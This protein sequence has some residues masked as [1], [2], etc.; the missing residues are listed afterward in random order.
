MLGVEFRGQAEALAGDMGGGA[1]AGRAEIQRAG[2]GFSR[3]DKIGN[4]LEALV[5]RHDQ[6]IRLRAEH[7][8]RREI[9]QW[10]VRQ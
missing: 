7:R 3:S 8:D 1:D 4:A 9:A 2:F 5:G 10:V 6:Y